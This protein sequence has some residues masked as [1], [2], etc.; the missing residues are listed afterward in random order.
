M[1]GCMAFCMPILPVGRKADC[2]VP[3]YVT[4]PPLPAPAMTPGRLPR[5]MRRLAGCLGLP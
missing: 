4:L 1:P 2:L 5:C 3:V